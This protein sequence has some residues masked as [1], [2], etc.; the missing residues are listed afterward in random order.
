MRKKELQ[1]RSLS[2][3]NHTIAKNLHKFPPNTDLVVGVPRSGLMAANI[4]A[5]H[6]HLP[7]TDVN[8]FLNGKILSSGSRMNDTNKS[9]E[10]M[11][12]ILVVDDSLSTGAAMEK[13][14]QK[15]QGSYPDKSIQFAVAYLKPGMTHKVDIFL[16]ECAIPRVFEWNMMNH[17][18]INKSCVDI[19]G[20]L[21]KSPTFEENKDEKNYLHFLAN[22]Q[23][24]LR[25][26]YNVGIL[27]TDRLEKYRPQ[28]EAWLARHG[29]T[30]D[31]L[32][33]RNF[34]S[35]KG[36]R[37]AVDYGKF[38]GEIFA[39]QRNSTLFIESSYTQAKEI[40]KISGKPVYCVD[41]RQMIW[42]S[43]LAV[44]KRK[45]RSLQHRITQKLSLV[46]GLSPAS[47]N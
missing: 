29:I 3:L 46:A 9:F 32:I 35:Q 19:D 17:S 28:T 1:Y 11:K 38:K 2:D 45:F 25:T 15:I 18:I 23:P 8:S 42:P 7:L 10:S 21:C 20:V 27:V 22:A 24:L 34:S 40:V 31:H 16:E 37:Q 13:T 14:I 30:F 6:L 26:D 47:I 44:A 33:M 36:S 5:L 43:D 39:N 41:K 4:I 12:N